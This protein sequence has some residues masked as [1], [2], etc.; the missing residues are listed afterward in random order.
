M[1]PRPNAGRA[2]YSGNSATARLLDE[3]V[4][5]VQPHQCLERRTKHLR[6]REQVLVFR[7]EEHLLERG[8]DEV[9]LVLSHD[10]RDVVEETLRLVRVRRRDERAFHVTRVIPG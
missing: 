3:Q 2:W 10:L 4:L 1:P 9:D 6:R 8:Q 7:D 5:V